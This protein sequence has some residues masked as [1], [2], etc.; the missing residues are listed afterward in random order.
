MYDN[1]L[2]N[3]RSCVIG[4]LLSAFLWLIPSFSHANSYSFRTNQLDVADGSTYGG[5]AVQS[6]TLVGLVSAAGLA[7][8]AL[9]RVGLAD[10]TFVT[11]SKSIVLNA[12]KAYNLIG[13]CAANP[14]ACG[15]I[16]ASLAVT[17]LVIYLVV[18]NA[19]PYMPVN[20]LEA[21]RNSLGQSSPDVPYNF[22]P[23]WSDLS[24]DKACRSVSGNLKDMFP[25]L[26]SG[27]GWE[28][29]LAFIPCWQPIDIYDYRVNGN[30][31]LSSDLLKY[32]VTSG[33]AVF[34]GYIGLYTYFS[35][36]QVP[37]TIIET[38]YFLGFDIAP[39]QPFHAP[40]IVSTIPLPDRVINPVTNVIPDI[41]NPVVI[42]GAE[43]IQ[44]DNTIPPPPVI[45]SLNPDGSVSTVPINPSAPINPVII[46]PSP[47]TIPIDPTV[48]VT[49]DPTVPVP[50]VP[51]I[52]GVTPVETTPTITK[53]IIRDAIKEAI[54]DAEKEAEE[55][56][57]NTT[58][59]DYNHFDIYSYLNWG[60]S[61][62]PSGC[63]SDLSLEIQGYSLTISFSPVCEYA[64][65]INAFI[66]VAALISFVG[67]VVG[68][69]KS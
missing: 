41:Y 13:L 50:T 12:S 25:F 44:P 53:P 9:I 11:I 62:L 8:T 40:P 15:T 4:L 52:P 66:R 55:D 17:A 34:E 1:S 36:L 35:Q 33:V 26:S 16:G 56:A 32:G 60:D 47:V 61:W 2:V 59:P 65:A 46:P 69:L 64:P 43:P 45:S 19:V 22:P 37:Y 14:V 67:I 18:E 49:I 54:D 6:A 68:G 3:M 39:V 24:D 42:D 63:P 21:I 58:P 23:F 28:S 5:Q 31:V 7:T 48:P 27:Y 51:T 57:E 38:N 30:V 10:G 20:N 29:N